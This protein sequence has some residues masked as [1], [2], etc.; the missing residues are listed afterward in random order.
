VGGFSSGD[1]G[2]PLEGLPNP[3]G[4]NA[5]NGTI[6]NGITIS[7]DTVSGASTYCVYRSVS[8]GPQT[9]IL[10]A[11]NISG[12]SWLDDDISTGVPYWYWVTSESSG[13]ESCNLGIPDQGWSSESL[14]GIQNLTA[15]QCNPSYIEVEW[16]GVNSCFDVK[17]GSTVIATCSQNPYIDFGATGTHNYY[18]RPRNSCGELGTW[19]GPVV[20]ILASCLGND[21][22]EG[23]LG[24]EPGDPTIL[25]V[26]PEINNASK[27]KGPSAKGTSVGDS[28]SKVNGDDPSI[29]TPPWSLCLV[30]DAEITTSPI[31]NLDE[32]KWSLP[33]GGNWRLVGREGYADLFFL[34]GSDWEHVRSLRV[35]EIESGIAQSLLEDGIA[36]VVGT[37]PEAGTDVLITGVSHEDCDKDGIPDGCEI[38][39]GLALDLNI[40]GVPD[41]CAAD[42]NADGIVD[43]LDLLEV[44]EHFGSSINMYGD[45]TGDGVV[46]QSDVL[47]V[48]MEMSY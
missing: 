31:L 20:G 46:D 40:D 3:G 19:E 17:R 28:E 36:A 38:L 18:V 25:I 10:Q 37:V 8:E 30:G 7:W 44:L 14:G 41:S 5:T 43:S 4:V 27:R 35:E 11:C 21:L 48:L 22:P 39:L 47:A 33:L 24:T 23:L 29:A 26:P 42:I 13:D 2:S 9:A 15:S 16:Y 6:C 34:G 12:Q 1:I 32:S 45:V